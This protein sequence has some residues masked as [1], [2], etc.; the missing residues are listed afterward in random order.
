MSNL[1]EGKDQIELMR[2][3]VK[4]VDEGKE[5]QYKHI[6]RTDW[7]PKTSSRFDFTNFEY[8]VKSEPLVMWVNVREDLSTFTYPSKE[9]AELCADHRSA[10]IAVKMVEATDEL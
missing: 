10:R 4:A 1:Y 6:P 7:F 5:I 3:I 2:A 9:H 8:R